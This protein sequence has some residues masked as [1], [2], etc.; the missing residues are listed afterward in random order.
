MNPNLTPQVI[1]QITQRLYPLLTNPEE[2]L[3]EATRVAAIVN[4]TIEDLKAR[5]LL[6]EQEQPVSNTEK[7]FLAELAKDNPKWAGK[8][9]RVPPPATI[10]EQLRAYVRGKRVVDVARQLKV[11]PASV[12]GWIAGKYQPTKPYRDRIRLLIEEAGE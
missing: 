5:G 6:K 3:I 8:K 11:N 1:I 12:Y 2:I 7:S 10:A 9:V 4:A